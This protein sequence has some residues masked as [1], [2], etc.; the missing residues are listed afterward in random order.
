MSSV[1]RQN[2]QMLQQ[3]S[4]HVMKSRDVKCSNHSR[5]EVDVLRRPDDV[6]T[7][8]RQPA[9]PSGTS[10]LP[11]HVPSGCRGFFFLLGS[12]RRSYRFGHVI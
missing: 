2:R 12:L 9:G 4:I 5:V 3:T 6:D 8:V 10:K 1:T 11:S 7:K